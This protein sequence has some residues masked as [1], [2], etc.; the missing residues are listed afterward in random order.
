[1][2]NRLPPRFQVTR[3][4]TGALDKPVEGNVEYLGQDKGNADEKQPPGGTR[5]TMDEHRH[6]NRDN[7]HQNKVETKEVGLGNIIPPSGRGVE[8]G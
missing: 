4:Q 7:E 3:Q 6:P 8:Y 2:I 1:M 5:A